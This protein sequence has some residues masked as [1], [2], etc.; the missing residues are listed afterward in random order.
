MIDHPDQV[1]RLMDRLSAALPI[2]ARVTPET[3]IS[4]RT[5]RGVA[6]PAHCNVTWVSYA[7][8]EGGIVCRV[9]AELETSEVVFAS[10]THLRFDPRLAF[11]RDIVAYQ[12]HRVKRL[13]RR[14][15]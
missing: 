4:L 7:G 3:Q 11:T 13:H 2:P 14:Q 10:I 6:I 8:D 9:E 5:Q 12:K 15:S 1:D